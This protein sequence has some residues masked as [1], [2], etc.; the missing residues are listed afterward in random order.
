MRD[1]REKLY[2]TTH[3]A[4]FVV[5]QEWSVRIKDLQPHLLRHTP[6][7]VHFSGHGDLSGEIILE[8]ECGTAQRVSI[9]ALKGLFT[10]LKDN[11]ICVVL[12]S[13]YSRQQADAIAEIIPCVIGMSSAIDDQA[14]IA[15]SSSFYQALGFGCS[16]GKAFGLG[17][18]QIELDGLNQEDIP[19]L[20][21]PRIDPHT[22]S[23]I[24]SKQG[25]SSSQQT[26]LQG[27]VASEYIGRIPQ[28]NNLALASVHMS[29]GG[30]HSGW[31]GTDQLTVKLQNEGFHPVQLIS[32]CAQWKM[33]NDNVMRELKPEAQITWVRLSPWQS[34]NDNFVLPKMLN[35]GC[36]IHV[37][38]KLT[39]KDIEDS[40]INI[41]QYL[42]A[43]GSEWM[44][45]SIVYEVSA[46]VRTDSGHIMSG[47]IDYFFTR[48]RN[49]TRGILLT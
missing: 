48:D 45:S 24:S 40:E 30:S 44:A 4:R 19:K 41:S 5:K 9:A 20:I 7:I 36:M 34:G 18:S 25:D 13:C 12:N 6:Q 21:A 33:V 26:Y 32:C 14:A 10:I 16:L 37:G 15:F 17:C 42:V 29:L 47:T 8:N 23:L 49:E 43:P 2:A 38:F 22:V 3:A 31:G 39:P 1:V 28:N 46:Q 27:S 35:P 11:V